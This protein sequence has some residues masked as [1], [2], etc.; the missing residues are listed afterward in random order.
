M[1]K[2][3]KSLYAVFG[4][5]EAAYG[6]IGGELKQEKKKKRIMN[7][8]QHPASKEQIKEGAYDIEDNKERKKL[9]ALLTFEE[10]PTGKEIEERANQIA[11]L[12]LRNARCFQCGGK[13]LVPMGAGVECSNC[14]MDQ[15]VYVMIGGAPFLMRHLEFALECRGIKPLYAFS[16]RESREET[17]PDGSVKKIQIFR[18]LGFI[19]PKTPRLA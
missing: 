3:E 19:K 8:T 9:K 13:G 4:E 14:G 5:E 15:E 10:L 11:E 18:H 16:R 2:K 12:A 17:L 6:T 1:G 7:L